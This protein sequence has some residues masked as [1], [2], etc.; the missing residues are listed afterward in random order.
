ML[1]IN[2]S[3]SHVRTSFHSVQET[4]Q[5]KLFRA[6]TCLETE[7][8][9]QCFMKENSTMLTNLKK[10]VLH[11]FLPV[12]KNLRLCSVAILSN[13]ADPVWLLVNCTQMITPNI[14]CFRK[15]TL[16]PEN[17]ISQATNELICDSRAIMFRGTCFK[18]VHFAK[19]EKNKNQ[20]GLQKPNR[21]DFE[22]FIVLV[23]R[24]TNIPMRV[25][26]PFSSN[27][28]I[29]ALR[30]G[31]RK[32]RW[33]NTTFNKGFSTQMVCVS[34]PDQPSFSLVNTHSCSCLFYISSVSVC[35][36]SFDCNRHQ[37]HTTS[38]D[39][40]FCN[41]SQN[42]G[43]CHT[44]MPLQ[45]QSKCSPLLYLSVKHTCKSFVER[46]AE[47]KK[48]KPMK[49]TK[50]KNSGKSP[51]MIQ[52]STTIEQFALCEQ[53]QGFPCDLSGSVQL[54]CFHTSDI[55]IFR[56]D[57]N[58][59]I[60][61]CTSASH[62]QDCSHF[63][64][65]A[66]FKCPNF[67][68]VPWTYV[69]D[70]KWNCPEGIDEAK[71]L[72][73]H[74]R[75]CKNMFRC[76]NSL[77]C[78]HLNDLCNDFYD[79]PQGDDELLC[80]LSTASCPHGCTCLNLALF[81]NRV[82][83][84]IHEKLPFVSYSI[85]F[86]KLHLAH[87]L[88]ENP[89][90]VFLNLTSNSLVK[91]WSV[92]S[93]RNFRTIDLSANRISQIHSKCFSNFNH[94][95]FLS[96]GKNTIKR[97]QPWSFT[98]IKSSFSLDLSSNNISALS[99]ANIF[100]VTRIINLIL[101]NNPLGAIE[102]SVFDVV[103]IGSINTD[104][105]KVCCAAKHSECNSNPAWH[106]SCTDLLLHTSV[107]VAYFLVFLG[108]SSLNSISFLLNCNKKFRTLFSDTK[109]KKAKLSG[110]YRIII[111]SIN[112]LDFLY[113]IYLFVLWTGDL[114]YKNMFAFQEEV[115]RESTFCAGAFCIVT[116]FYCCVPVLFSYLALARFMVVKY[117]FDSVFK[118]SKLSVKCVS[119]LLV[120]AVVAG[121]SFTFYAK[122]HTIFTRLCFPLVSPVPSS[123][124]RIFPLLV[125][126]VQTVYLVFI[127]TMYFLMHRHL[128]RPDDVLHQRTTSNWHIS[129]QVVLTIC[130]QVISWISTSAIFT[131]SYFFP[132]KVSIEALFW[133]I[134]MVVPFISVINPAVVIALF[135]KQNM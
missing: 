11:K 70:G 62:L 113:G 59:Q 108:V 101:V 121:G 100:N 27:T 93:S 80:F 79:C 88:M 106:M 66:N 20:C 126:S 98:S 77:L 15:D 31:W 109:T 38:D 68:C 2:F 94:L 83:I 35:D 52:K 82:E 39:E 3:V 97:L 96:L 105:Y 107:R 22:T 41:N 58:K 119:C 14:V 127:A 116:V 130:T 63:E 47:N 78:A 7:H 10:E 131:A 95:T 51:Y 73:C 71:E 67:Y 42:H 30:R 54:N 53:A 114:P 129:V 28:Q 99:S 37:N 24:G 89:N 56:L 4:K 1:S 102:P 86:S 87:F 110:S 5:E 50:R 33:F 128:E 69:C 26:N 115:W 16:E 65:Q 57:R 43:G 49:P 91:M 90:S 85:I 55:C 45:N 44:R 112:V 117:P 76:K 122:N 132:G 12:T 123:P 40:S 84:S 48:V 13:L 125:A 64:C 92:V 32:L 9:Q 133:I 111:S 81:C 75:E 134:G 8:S 72:T 46:P 103:G 6:I 124:L 74:K 18:L 21:T 17:I 23:A 36:G 60:T 19:K 120:A 135:V 29:L 34:F 104:S 25:V 61:P 118:S